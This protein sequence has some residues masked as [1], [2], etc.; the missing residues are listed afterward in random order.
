MFLRQRGD[1]PADARFEISAFVDQTVEL[2]FRTRPDT[3]TAGGGDVTIIYCI[4]FSKVP[5]PST[6]AL[7]APGAGLL[8]RRWLGRQ[9]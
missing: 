8:G 5:E 9:R 3:V 1:I 4:D 2:E 7:L 6:Y